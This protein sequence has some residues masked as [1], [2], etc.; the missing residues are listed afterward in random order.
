MTKRY[1]TPDIL[2]VANYVNEPIM[3]ASGTTLEKT[4]TVIND[5]DEFASR[6]IIP[7]NLW[8]DEEDDEED[9]E[10]SEDSEEQSGTQINMIYIPVIIFFVVLAYIAR[11][12]KFRSFKKI[13]L[14]IYAMFKFTKKITCLPAHSDYR[15]LLLTYSPYGEE[16]FSDYLA[17]TY[18]Q[19]KQK[20]SNKTI[21]KAY[22]Q[23]KKQL[24]T[25]LKGI[26][27]LLGYVLL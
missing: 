10:E 3:A 16:I 4:D 7:N 6:T 14:K 1:I 11:M 23:I 18:S 26:K 20:H 15:A 9:E 19:N 8:D 2:V 22:S 21:A 27:K 24:I 17:E 25:E 13:Y 12:P 5:P